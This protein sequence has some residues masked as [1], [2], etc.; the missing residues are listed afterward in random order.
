MVNTLRGEGFGPFMCHPVEQLLFEG[1]Q[2]QGYLDALNKIIKNPIVVG[3]LNI[4]GI[5]IPDIPETLPSN[6]QTFGYFSTVR[7]PIEART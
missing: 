5:E 2:L 6:F 7:A 3:I 1:W 4:L